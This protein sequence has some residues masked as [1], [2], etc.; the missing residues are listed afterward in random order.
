MAVKKNTKVA[1]EISIKLD[2]IAHEY[3]YF[4]RFLLRL[5]DGMVNLQ[6]F[7]AENNSEN[8]RTVPILN[9]VATTDDFAGLI[10][11]FK[12]YIAKIGTPAIDDHFMITGARNDLPPITFQHLGVISRAEMGELIIS[13]FSHKTA[14]DAS[15]KPGTSIDSKTYG[16]YTSTREIHK[17]VIFE[18]VQFVEKLASQK[19]A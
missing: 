16:V 5:I 7:F 12:G 19:S 15:L 14:H 8:S 11:N 6:L 18:L 17:K 13:Q 1:E 10:A 2:G 3:M 9:A 4:N